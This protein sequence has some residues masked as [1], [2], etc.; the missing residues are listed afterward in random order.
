MEN[1]ATASKESA[2]ISMKNSVEIS[3][4]IRGKN[5]DKAKNLLLKV[6]EK[7][8]AVPFKRYYHDIS[9]KKGNIAAGR[10]PIATA[11]YFLEIINDVEANAKQKGMVQPY[12]IIYLVAN[13]GPKTWHYGRT[14]GIT[15][16]R[17]HLEIK[18]REVKKIQPKE[19]V[20]KT[21]TKTQ[22]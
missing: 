8:V 1:I 13:K 18:V 19:S 15:T 5:T 16:K 9:H 3:S 6:L 22:K 20:K 17:T 14:R 12:K 10:Y 11:K 21:E 2:P 7:K 4:F